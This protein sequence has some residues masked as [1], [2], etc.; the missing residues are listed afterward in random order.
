MKK[1]IVWVIMAGSILLVGCWKTPTTDVSTEGIAPENKQE[2]QNVF[3]GTAKDLLTKEDNVSCSFTFEDNDTKEE[4]TIYIYK[5]MMKSVAKVQLK[6]EN[7]NLEAYTVTKD[8]YTYTRSNIQKSQWAKFKTIPEWTNE[9]AYSEDPLGEKEVDFVC[10]EENLQENMFEI[11][12]DVSFMDI[13][14]YLKNK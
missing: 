1:F 14:D 13:T 9:E 11:P 3:K 12:S 4:G 2:K 5:G 6:K 7:M 8:G 10:K